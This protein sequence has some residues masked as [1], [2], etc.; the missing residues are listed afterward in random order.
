M[1]EQQGNEQGQQSGRRR[2][3]RLHGGEERRGEEVE[4]RGGAAGA[5]GDGG[6]SGVDVT[7][8]YL[9]GEICGDLITPNTTQIQDFNQDTKQAETLQRT[10]LFYI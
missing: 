7:V 2:G 8:L 9:T 3:V 1:E 6:A 4:W 10:S 5:A